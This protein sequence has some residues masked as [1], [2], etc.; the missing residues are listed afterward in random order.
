MFG[1]AEQ[2]HRHPFG[3]RAAVGD[4]QDFRGAGDH[5]DADH[6]KYAPF[7]G[8]DVGVARAGDFIDLRDAFGA[9]G[10]RGNGLRA[11]DGEDL[12]HACHICRRQHDVVALALRRRHDHDDFRHAGDVRGHGVHDDCARICRLA[13]GNVDA[14]AVQRGDLL[15]EQG[16]VC[17]GVVPGFQFLPAVI[18]FDARGGGLQ[19]VAGCGGQAGKGCLQV[20]RRQRQVGD[21]ACCRAVEAVGVFDQGGIATALHVGTDFG[22]NALGFGVLCGFKGKQRFEFGGEGRGAGGQ[23]FHGGSRDGWVPHYNGC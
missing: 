10:Q 12:G 14:D 18:V 13:A 22:D 15:A 21:A 16:A 8:G 5:V 19:G 11:P 7:G 20:V 9:V 3:G 6:A 1:L 23:F 2:V 17:V 4:D